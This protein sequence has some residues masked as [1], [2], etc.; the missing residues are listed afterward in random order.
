MVNMESTGPLNSSM[1]WRINDPAEL[2]AAQEL[3]VRGST[4]HS[5]ALAN[6]HLNDPLNDPRTHLFEEGGLEARTFWLAL[7][8]LQG[9]PD[10]RGAYRT[11]RAFM[12]VRQH[13]REASLDSAGQTSGIT[14]PLGA[15][16]F[17]NALLGLL[18]LRAWMQSAKGNRK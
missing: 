10:S 15:S 14:L 8:A 6:H 9:D 7:A 2:H 1:L 18:L 12:A 3:A 13:E 16:L 4:S 5:V 11:E 17:L